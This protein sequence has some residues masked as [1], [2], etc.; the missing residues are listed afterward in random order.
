MIS[1][2]GVPH[3]CSTLK[4]YTCL[5]FVGNNCFQ[6]HRIIKSVMDRLIG[7]FYILATSRITCLVSVA[8]QI[9]DIVSFNILKTKR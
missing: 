3:F 7:I 1:W 9:K 4:S 6:D 2:G 5:I 8:S